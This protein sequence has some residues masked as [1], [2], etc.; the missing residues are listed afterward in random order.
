MLINFECNDVNA[1]N[2]DFT[3]FIWFYAIYLKRNSHH[4]ASLMHNFTENET[5]WPLR[6]VIEHALLHSALTNL[7]SLRGVR[8]ELKMWLEITLIKAKRS[9]SSLLPSIW[10]CWKLILTK[11][12]IY[13]SILTCKAP[14]GQ[15]LFIINGSWFTEDFFITNCLFELFQKLTLFLGI[16]FYSWHLC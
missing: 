1:W 14:F 7:T 12:A 9:K 5:F 10:R 4:E 2:T 13:R 16:Y 3:H 6:S 11:M 8:A 15:Q